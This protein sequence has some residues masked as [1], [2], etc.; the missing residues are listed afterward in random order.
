M[1]QELNEKINEEDNLNINP[2]NPKI[3][4]ALLFCKLIFTY[5]NSKEKE[6]E[7][8]GEQ[9]VLSKLTNDEHQTYKSALE[10]I[11]HYIN[12]ELTFEN[13]EPSPLTQLNEKLKNEKI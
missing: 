5:R 2:L 9:N 6:S 12:G 8:T 3:I 1:D 13:H 11:K 7:H 4:T 10:V